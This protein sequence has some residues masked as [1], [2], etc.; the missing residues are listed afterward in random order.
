MGLKVTLIA[1]V[2]PAVKELPHVVASLKSVLLVPVTPTV[3]ICSTLL[4]VLETWIEAGVLLFPIASGSKFNLP[5]ETVKKGPFKPAP[6]SGMTCGLLLVPSV[7]VIAP[8]LVPVVEGE[9]RTLIV[10]FCLG[11]SLTP[12]LFVSVKSPLMEIPDI[13]NDT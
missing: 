13:P 4:P 2:L 8:V 12:Q 9:N 11:A 10:Q 6:V 7:S 3:E 5:G 1:Q